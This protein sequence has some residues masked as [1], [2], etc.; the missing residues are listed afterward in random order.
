MSFGEVGCT[1]EVVHPLSYPI[2]VTVS[3]DR[4]ASV[5]VNRKRMTPPGTC[6]RL[7][8]IQ[9]FVPIQSTWVDGNFCP[10]FLLICSIRSV[11]T[12]VSSYPSPIKARSDGIPKPSD[13][14]AS[15]ILFASSGVRRRLP[16]FAADGGGVGVSDL[17]VK[18]AFS[19]AASCASL[20]AVFVS[21]PFTRVT[22]NV[23]CSIRKKIE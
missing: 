19:K 3:P 18:P 6:P 5:A 16:P 17:R 12:K 9:N 20:F 23:I 10:V 7:N 15:A 2:S 14:L 8:R 21:L 4:V 22:G 11:I 1:T 13:R